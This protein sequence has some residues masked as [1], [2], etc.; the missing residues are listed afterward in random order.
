MSTWLKAESTFR[1]YRLA[2]G[3]LWTVQNEYQHETCPHCSGQQYC[4]LTHV[5]RLDP[6]GRPLRPEWHINRRADLQELKS[7]VV[8]YLDVAATVGVAEVEHDG[9]WALESGGKIFGQ[10]EIS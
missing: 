6:E 4:R 1:Q 5:L 8:T 3:A 7:I 9:R 2:D 10:Q